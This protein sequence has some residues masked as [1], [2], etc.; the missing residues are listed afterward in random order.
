MA[1]LVGRLDSLLGENEHRGRQLAE[2]DEE[3]TR[4]RASVRESETPAPA[5]SASAQPSADSAS[6]GSATR[7][8]KAVVFKGDN[9]DGSARNLARFL[10]RLENDFTLYPQQFPSDAVK[11]AYAM[12]D[13]GETADQWVQQFFEDDPD[14]VRHDW[15]AFQRAIKDHF[16]DPDLKANAR[17]ELLQLRQSH[18]RSILEF[19]T[20]FETLCAQAMW[21]R[22]AR[23]S[24]FMEGLDE[25]IRRQVEA[26]EVNV[27]DYNQVKLKATWLQSIADK[28]RT[29]PRGGGGAP[30]TAQVGRNPNLSTRGDRDRQASERD[31]QEQL[32]FNCHKPGHRARDCPEK[33][34]NSELKNLEDTRENESASEK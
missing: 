26:S 15:G 31:R 9:Y 22:D 7:A 33:R 25:S 23:A 3:V 17:Q 4:F 14:G 6:V 2:R 34:I 28:G 12:S 24:T 11:V 10:N 29:G 8:S 18:C 21:Q 16:G 13:L 30:R 32:C 27:L 19:V 20:R 1:A 5:L